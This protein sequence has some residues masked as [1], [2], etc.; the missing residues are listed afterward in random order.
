[1]P[2][3]DRAYGHY[4]EPSR[5]GGLARRVKKKGK[6]TYAVTAGRNDSN[7]PK[8]NAPKPQGEKPPKGGS[9]EKPPQGPKGGK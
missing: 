1:M 4:H 6:A 8:P 9:K 5:S 7:K 3:H 2:R